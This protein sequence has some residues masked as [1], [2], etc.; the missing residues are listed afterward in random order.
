MELADYYTYFTLILDKRLEKTRR[1][2]YFLAH[3]LGVMINLWVKTNYD[4]EL[5]SSLS[6]KIDYI[7]SDCVISHNMSINVAMDAL[8]ELSHIACIYVNNEQYSHIYTRTCE[9]I[10]SI[11][12]SYPL[13]N[14]Y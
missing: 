1:N 4:N 13:G 6:D 2:D 9:Q 7:L 14:L 5:L 3:Y 8:V 10:K 11:L 12:N